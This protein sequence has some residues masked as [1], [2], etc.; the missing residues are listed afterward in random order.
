MVNSFNQGGS[1]R[2]AVQL[3]KLLHDE[4][5]H[6]IFLAT[7]NARGE[8]LEEVESLG[9]THLPEFRLRSFYDIN[10][11]NQLRKCVGFIRR[12]QI[13]IIHTHDFYTNIFGIL[14]ASA[15]RVRLKISSKRETGGMRGKLQRTTER[16]IFQWSDAIVVNSRAVK[17]YLLDEGI[18]AR[19]IQVIY[20]GVD[21]DRLSLQ[22]LDRPGICRRLGLPG[23]KGINFIPIVANLRHHVKNHPMFIK[24]AAEVLKSFPETHFVV[25]GEGELSSEIKRLAGEL[26]IESRVHFI[27][28]C[29]MIPELLSISYAG[30]LTSRAEG[31]SNSILEYMASGLPVVAT[32]VGG[33]SEVIEDDRSGF[34]IDSDDYAALAK[35][36]VW[37]IEHPERASEMG[38]RGRA[39]IAQQFSCDAQLRK[40]LWMYEKAVL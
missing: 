36:L 30:I 3:T 7:L 40:T 31:F 4:G 25:A 22:G 37:L 24:G 8:L 34:L 6:N 21:L 39:I 15:A 10:F 11:A 26:G 16:K 27:G 19:K 20:N 32:N 5:S 23:E 38:G 9:L 2:Q 35:K 33:A 29:S 1:E 13:D 14:A 18:S 12:N 28:S 17:D